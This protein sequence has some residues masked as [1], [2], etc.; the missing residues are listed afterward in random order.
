MA[1]ERDLHESEDLLDQGAYLAR[2]GYSGC[3]EPTAET[4]RC[5]H[6]AHATKIPFENLDILLGKT[7]SLDLLALQTKLVAAHRGGYCFEHNTLF[8]AVLESLGFAVT[9]LAARV[10]FGSTQVRPRSHM[11][12]SV[13]L[14]DGP[15]LADVGFGGEGLLEPIRLNRPDHVQQW[16]WNFRV[17][18]EGEINVLQ[19]LHADGWFDLYAF[20]RERQYPVDY[21]VSN[22]FTSTYPRSPFVQALL[23]QRTSTSARWTLKDLELTEERPEGKTLT[24]LADSNALLAT[25]ADVFDLHFPAGTRFI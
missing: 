4:L 16:A 12:L 21:I 22:H 8:A 23:V 5:L 14:D 11:L 17:R 7:I 19:A 20:G 10:R 24:I 3:L 13:E 1:E 15:W 25:L 9:R 6:F 2:I 18:A